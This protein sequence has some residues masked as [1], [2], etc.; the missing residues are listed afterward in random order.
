RSFFYWNNNGKLEGPVRQEAPIVAWDPD[1][2]FPR[3]FR[4]LDVARQRLTARLVKSG[5]NVEGGLREALA[6]DKPADRALALRGLAAL[7]RLGPLVDALEDEMHPDVRGEAF[8]ALRNWIGRGEEQAAKLYDGKKRTGILVDKKY[9]T[10]EAESVLEL[11][12][13]FPR[14]ALR[15]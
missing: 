6:S 13:S 14:P 15:Q 3:E 11:L 8:V 5:R 9:R 7:A 4:E 10:D 12:D 2:R 1:Q